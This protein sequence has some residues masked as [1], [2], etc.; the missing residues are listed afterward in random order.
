MSLPTVALDDKYERDSGRVYITGSQALL[1][2]AMNQLRRDEAAGLDT[3]CYISGYRGSP[4]HNVDKELWRAA[5]YLDEGRIR[6]QPG[7]NED[8]AATACLGTQQA[9][10]FPD[11]KHDG[12][13]AMWYGKGPGVDRCGDVFKHGNSAGVSAHGGVLLLAG[14]MLPELLRRPAAQAAAPEAAGVVHTDFQRGFI[15]AEVIRWDELLDIGSWTKAKELGKIR[16]EGKDYV[17]QDGDVLEI[18]FN[19]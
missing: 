8:L 14:C 9:A 10:M 1:R 5:R 17:V 18:R 4:M 13:C 7:I 2:L 12:V 6:F 3:A 16:I 19:V 11:A 15:K